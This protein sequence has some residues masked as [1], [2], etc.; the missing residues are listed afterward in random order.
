M[1][2]LK[3]SCFCSLMSTCW[4]AEETRTVVDGRGV[5]VQIPAEINRV[6]TVCAGLIEST[7]LVLGEE[8][9]IVGV[10]GT[11]Q[12]V[13]NYSYPTVSGEAYEY[14]NGTRPVTYLYPRIRDLPLVGKSS[15]SVS[16]ETLAGLDP[17][18]V[19]L[20]IY[21]S[22]EDEGT[23]KTISTIEGLGIPVVVLKGPPCFDKPDLSTISD[24][25]RIIGKVFEKEER[26]SKLADYLESQTQAVFERTKDIRLGE[27]NCPHIRRIVYLPGGGRSRQREGDRHD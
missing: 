19:I 25:I 14:Q 20:R 22:M 23:Q 17:D 5:E 12:Q 26:A 24:E 3:K 6:V 10:S 8:E 15:S 16:Y 11:V 27:T 13:Y 21:T 4:A 2:L 18:L 1:R 7:M 9:K